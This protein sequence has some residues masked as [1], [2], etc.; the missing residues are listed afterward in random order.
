M[1]SAVARK[2]CYSQRYVSKVSLNVNDR[3]APAGFKPAVEYLL[4]ALKL[5]LALLRRNGDVVNLVPM[6]VGDPLYARQPLQLLDG[7]DRDN[8]RDVSVNPR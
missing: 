4:D 8:L 2:A 1:D 7:A 6:K 3:C 5:T